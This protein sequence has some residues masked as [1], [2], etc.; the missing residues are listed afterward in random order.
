LHRSERW[1]HWCGIGLEG[2]LVGL[3]GGGIGVTASVTKN[4]PLLDSRHTPLHPHG[5]PAQAYT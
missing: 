4:V 3:E 5:N 1:W 2:G